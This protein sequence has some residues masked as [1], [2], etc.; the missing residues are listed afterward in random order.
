MVLNC[1]AREFLNEFYDSKKIIE[2][3]LEKRSG[4]A[5]EESI[6]AIATFMTILY[7]LIG[8]DSVYTKDG[9]NIL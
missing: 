6:N 8:P 3:E 5:D 9:V 7:L 1:T 4:E 2:E